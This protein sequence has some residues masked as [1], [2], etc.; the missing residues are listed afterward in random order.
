VNE[1]KTRAERM[2]PALITQGWTEKKREEFLEDLAFVADR[3]RTAAKG[4]GK[5]GGK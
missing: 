3:C 1:A 2:D 5:A 4:E